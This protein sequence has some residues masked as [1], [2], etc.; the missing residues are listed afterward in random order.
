MRIS[1][2]EFRGRKLFV[3]KSGLR[4]TTDRVRQALFNILGPLEGRD[5]LDLYAGSG[6]VALEAFSRGGG[7]VVA[8]E[9]DRRSC[10]V[11][12]QNASGIRAGIEVICA[13]VPVLLKN[14]SSGFFDIVFLDPPYHSGSDKAVFADLDWGTIVAEGGTIV[15][16]ASSR[17]DAPVFPG[18]V[19][20]KSRKYGESA[21]YFF[22][23]VTV[24][25]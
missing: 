23:K 21:L 25:E 13:S 12:A 8:V 17:E 16:E 18:F 11:V 3:P 10:G 24:A 1:G 5:F 14:W 22:E 20:G 15:F 7:R 2:G 9:R 19:L 6:S 4:P